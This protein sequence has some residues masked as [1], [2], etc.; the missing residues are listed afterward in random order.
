MKKII[1]FLERLTLTRKLIWGI[2]C[3]IVIGLLL[4][5]L[6]ISHGTRQSQR[7]EHVYASD[8]M[9]LSNMKEANIQLFAVG[10]A[11]RQMLLAPDATERLRAQRE[12][13]QARLLL[14]AAMRD[15]TEHFVSPKN[16]QLHLATQDSI[17]SFLQNVDEILARQ[18]ASSNTAEASKMLFQ[19]RNM[20]IFASSNQ[21]MDE[22][23]KAKET[24]ARQS[25]REALAQDQNTINLTL[26]LLALSLLLAL[27][28]GWLLAVTVRNPIE[29]LRDSVNNMAL[30]QLHITV[31]YTDFSNEIGSMAR[32]IAVLQQSAQQTETLRWV[33]AAATDVQ[34]RVLHIEQPE[35]FAQLL[36]AQICP[37]LGAQS[38]LLYVWHEAHQHFVLSGASGVSNLSVVPPSFALN[39][40]LLGQC[41]S[42]RKPLRLDHV[43]EPHL[44]LSSGLL[45]AA[46]GTV[47]LEPVRA[48][49]S[50]KVLA[51][52]E[53]CSLGGFDPRH[54]QLLDEL[55]PL[56]IT[57]L[58][59]MQR[60]QLTRN[61]LAQT[62][63]Q[64][65]NL[66]RSEEELQVQQEEL[67]Q[68]THE[69]RRQQLVIEIAKGQAEAASHAKSE[70]L[71]NMSHEI[72]TPMNAVIGLS[73][74]ALKTELDAKQRDYVQKIF[75]EGRALL[76][77]INDIL[78]FS[79]IEAAKL[80]LET[81][82]FWL[83]NVLNS[84]GTLMAHNAHAKDVEFLIHVQPDVPQALLGDAT[85]FKQVLV[86][87][88][89][90][91]IKF[92]ERGQVELS[93]AVLQRQGRRM[94]LK[95]A[96]RDTGIGMTE[97]QCSGLF[98]SFTQADSSTTRRF[99]GSGLGL[100]ICKSLLHLM[101]GDIEV[102]STPG[103]GSIFT[104]TLWLGADSQS[105][106]FGLASNPIKRA[107]RVL[108]VDDN[109]LARQI[110][111]E[112]LT[113]LG[114]RH[115]AVDSG[116]AALLA[117]QD[118]DL[119]D[120]FDL[121]L[122]DW[123]MPGLDG[124][125]TT[126][127]V[128]QDPQLA[129]H[130]AVVMV[131]GFGADEVRTAGSQAGARAFLEKPV[132]LSRLWD[133]LAGMMDPETARLHQGG[134]EDSHDG[135]LAGMAVLLVEDK[136]INQ[137]V[138]S[139]LLAAMGV[140]VT[141]A[142]NGQQALDQLQEASDPLPW[143]LVL[144]DLQ[145]PVMDGIDATRALRAQERFKALPII[146]LTAHASAHEVER[147]LTEGM[148]AHLSKPID[149]D[150]LFYCLKQWGQAARPAAQPL[151][152]PPQTADRY[153]RHILG[154]DTQRGL[155]L[156]AGNQPLYIR[157]L[158]DFLASIRRLP[159][160]LASALAA[161]QWQ[162]AERMVHGLKGTAAN[163]GA[164][165]CSTL[166]GEAEH[167]LSQALTQSRPPPPDFMAPLLA[168]LAQLVQSLQQGLPPQ[169]EASL[170][171]PAVNPA[172]LKAT[173]R[174]LA[175]LLRANKYEAD[176]LLRAQC[177]LLRT[178]LGTGFAALE[179][180]VQSFAFA[181]ALE[182][183]HQAARAAGIALDE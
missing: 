68:Q 174:A 125:E 44:R 23:V 39:E 9:G 169:P 150:A 104:A 178:G 94:Q 133:T 159:T 164:V 129:H 90:N 57:N 5:V 182:T 134:P 72:R 158:H 113:S 143:H 100:A 181:E 79:K 8:L 32:A 176:H 146:A 138:A 45:D 145:M 78:D 167:L 24:S 64:A 162:T 14:L 147:C 81:A 7:L 60:N 132:G 1:T 75:S 76:G 13:A 151:S 111:S 4:S 161:Q 172:Q 116:Q 70:F 139:E 130:P 35:A 65:E 74:L 73:Q 77:I 170:T 88:I 99:G 15:S 47:L 52:L 42:Q 155:L 28:I 110:L 34:A 62:Q 40:G 82:P 148:N 85:R 84:L 26:L 96:V 136:E 87:L 179:Q 12:L 142:N 93:L 124:I 80:T 53:L 153:E 37:L 2:G 163:L 97:Q 118:A 27:T 157:L 180:Q 171:D 108:V 173:C 50:Q 166:S 121:V 144:M 140:R 126:R 83:D 120:P 51:L 20:K 102:Q 33:K 141:L 156:C 149:P 131:T 165:H 22:L 11:L 107:L 152:Q 119:A 168:E 135:A 92:T 177:K 46:P 16:K 30:G 6:S 114:L 43:G 95:V 21:L 106:R 69:L 66:Q 91:A 109:A 25:L 38:G 89:S 137:Q 10:R 183:L 101:D 54:R 63:A 160:D 127:R 41:A 175:A 128:V 31:P 117:L 61:L 154:I 59:I 71:A 115:Q 58:E 86:N 112:Q 36:L 17:T 55:L 19:D 18:Q 105:K 123:Q 3:L 67:L 56:I 48:F 103:V 49:G 98:H 122:M 29:R